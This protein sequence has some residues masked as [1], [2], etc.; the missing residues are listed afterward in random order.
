MYWPFVGLLLGVVLRVLVPYVRSGLEKV[1]ESGSFNSWP[2]FDYRYLALVLLPLLEFAIAFLTV[3]GLWRAAFGW[4]FIPSVAMAYVGYDISK[5]IVQT[6]SAGI[7][8][9][10]D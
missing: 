6:I 10:Q 9:A 1:A 4:E 5:E 3:P 2:V 8:I 7:R